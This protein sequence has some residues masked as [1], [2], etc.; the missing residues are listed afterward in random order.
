MKTVKIFKYRLTAFLKRKAVNPYLKVSE[1]D[2]TMASGRQ[3][4]S[5]IVF[6]KKRLYLD[7]A[8]EI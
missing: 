1:D 8:R 6:G 4:Q 5:V 3:F 2:E 7:M